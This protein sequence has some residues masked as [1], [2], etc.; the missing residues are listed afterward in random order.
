MTEQI[1]EKWR[2]L[3]EAGLDLGDPTGSKQEV[4]PD[5]AFQQYRNG[6][7]YRQERL[8]TF[9]VQGSMLEK[10]NE[11][12]TSQLGFPTSDER[13]T[14]DGLYPAQYFERG[15]VIQLRGG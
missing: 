8:G 10:Y 4:G 6:T 2:Q 9:L 15:A 1:E 7:I 12:G 14:D 13:E 3:K 11:V 5:G